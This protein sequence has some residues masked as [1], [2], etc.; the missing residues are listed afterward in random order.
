MKTDER[1]WKLY[2]HINKING[3]RYVGITSKQKVEH[4]W[5]S[6]SGYKEN[7]HFYSAI[8]KYGWDGFEHLV[9]HKSLTK[10]EANAV[11]R[12]LISLWH[13][14]DRKYGYN[15]TS[16]GEGTPNYHPSE[17]TRAKLSEAR[18][19]ENLSKE[20]LEK[21]SLGL[22]GR[23]FTAEHKQ[24]IGEANSKPINMYDLS[25]TFIRSFTSAYEAESIL[26][27]NHSH[28]SQCCH[29]HRQTTGG[30]KW[31]FAQN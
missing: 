29:G 17:E 14:Q 24:K 15:M 30:Y 28:I 20:T 6:G 21:R 13:T 8:Q 25:G 23:K 9:L 18:R 10:K 22:K 3:K 7:P 12:F 31:S 26:R 5:E 16:G 1:R 4:R 11:E 27:I 2:V 19:K